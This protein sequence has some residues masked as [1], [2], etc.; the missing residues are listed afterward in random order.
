MKKTIKIGIIIFILGIVLVIFGIANNGIQSVYWEN[1][2]H[3]VRQRSQ[4]Y[5]PKTI[6]TITVNTDANVTIKRGAT[7]SIRVVSARQLPTVSVKDGHVSVTSK[8]YD[9]TNTVG[10][11]ITPLVTNHVVITVPKATTIDRIKSAPKQ[12]GDVK[13]Q[14]VNADHVQ[15]TAT[16]D[17]DIS[18][19][20]VQVTNDLLTSGA[21]FTATNVAAP[22]LTVAGEDI[23]IKE[24]HFEAQDSTINGSDGDLTIQTSHF[25]NVNAKTG[26]GDIQ[27]TDNHVNGTFTAKTDDGDIQL[28]AP[29]SIGVTAQNGDDDDLNIFGWHSDSQHQYQY[30]TNATQQYR[31]TTSDGD[32]T[33]SAS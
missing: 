16:D 26:D 12:S 22:S 19:T 6:K 27:L 17:S 3:V 8:N 30:Q 11:L 29:R 18:L 14:D 23:N 33:V 7:S 1:G 31:L 2:F 32:I 13:L 15:L 4:T 28:T 20:N 5:H 25:K 24:S 9:E 21:D 10:F